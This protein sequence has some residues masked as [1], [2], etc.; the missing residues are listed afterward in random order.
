MAMH[1]RHVSISVL[2]LISYVLSTAAVS[3]SRPSP[4]TSDNISPIPIG[5][6]GERS[7][8]RLTTSV[9]FEYRDIRFSF[10]FFGDPI[11]KRD[12]ETVLTSADEAITDLVDQHPFESITNNRFEHRA[13]GGNTLIS[14]Q[15][16]VGKRITWTQ[17]FRLLQGLY[18][19]M[20]GMRVRQQHCQVLDFSVA[21]AGQG[22]VGL[23]VIRY[24]PRDKDQAQKRGTMSASNTPLNETVLRLPKKSSLLP[25]STFDEKPLLWPVPR[26][27]LVLSIHFAGVPI[28]KKNVKATLQGAMAEVRPWSSSDDG[29][30][31]IHHN[32]FDWTLP[33]NGDDTRTGVTVM[34]YHNCLI[35]WNQ[36]F[37][38]LFG[39]YQFTT[40]FDTNAEQH[41]QVLGFRI[42]NKFDLKIGVGTLSYYPRRLTKVEKRASNAGQ[43]S[44]Q[45]PTLTSPALAAVTNRSSTLWP[46][47]DTSVVLDFVSLG[48]DI[49][50]LQ[51][52]ET[53]GS[54]QKY[55]AD[56]VRRHPRT[57]ILDDGFYFKPE[58]SDAYINI[59][60]TQDKSMSWLELSQVLFG[61]MQFCDDEHHRVLVFDIDVGGMRVGLG[62]LLYFEPDKPNK[63]EKQTVKGTL[64]V[65]NLVAG[66]TSIPYNIPNTKDYLDFNSFGEAIP[67]S[68]VLEALTS[69]L[70]DISDFVQGIPDSPVPRNRYVYDDDFGISIAILP[71]TFIRMTWSQ[72]D[73]ILTGLMCFVTGVNPRPGGNLKTHYQ[74][75]GF[76]IIM[77]KQGYIG[78]GLLSYKPPLKLAVEKRDALQ[79]PVANITMDTTY[80][81]TIPFHV[82]GTPVTLVLTP[83]S[84]PVSSQQVLSMLSKAR[85]KIS[86]S[87]ARRPNSRVARN[88]FE[89]TTISDQGDGTVSVLVHAY[90]GHNLTWSVV[91]DVCAGLIAVFTKGTEKYRPSLRFEVDVEEVGRIGL[92]IVWYT[93]N[94]IS[95]RNVNPAKPS[96]TSGSD[97]QQAGQVRSSENSSAPG[98]DQSDIHFPILDTNITLVFTKLGVTKIPIDTVN[99]FFHA[100]TKDI[101]SSIAANSNSA[102]PSPLWYFKLD[103]IHG[104]ATLS[105]SI[106][107][108]TNHT[109]KWL[110]LQKI[111][112]ALELFMHAQRSPLNFDIDIATDVEVGK[113]L[114]WY[115]PPRLTTA[116]KRASPQTNNP[117]LPLSHP[118][119]PYPIPST[120]ITLTINLNGPPIP[121]F[122]LTTYLSTALDHI[123]A[124]VTAIP[125]APVPHNTYRYSDRGSGL[126]G[127]YIAYNDSRWL[128]WRQLG[129]I[130]HGLLAFVG[131]SEGHSRAMVAEV[132]VEGARVG[133]FILWYMYD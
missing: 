20:V 72:L 95:G 83:L 40:A 71:S 48:Q 90:I 60:T 52:I 108:R 35:T 38:I 64:T 120:P 65:P 77:Q 8:V 2:P 121:A 87:V 19:F 66:S 46:V 125:D 51:I 99:N 122:Y 54:A 126:S 131:E 43:H 112:S 80:P 70:N 59:V 96:G 29:D 94:I 67:T 127:E 78:T 57:S 106:Y 115:S 16:N 89:Y 47:R 17:L 75:L 42:V 68:K 24:F 82:H 49:P 105:I 129:W 1:V 10:T 14:I 21:I 45:L 39:L 128:K 33:P 26:T 97:P 61:V 107:T 18:R 93:P 37:Q 86:N 11:P 27:S 109:L 36:L 103:S 73:K 124:N 84:A 22:N 100:V 88:W 5:T 113:G 91:D 9:P 31:A 81:T 62:T 12:V 117:P 114:I 56:V 63:M 130:L 28:P 79:L 110:Q 123:H 53:L 116:A 41:F 50:I 15:A 98:L 119:I 13:I 118:P 102:I 76:N 23:G 44:L 3:L 6:V 74:V 34:A 4:A 132:D 104:G 85:G 111:L 92:G 101:Q 133:V 58:K 25:A 30:E 69:I 7:P 32:A 55:V